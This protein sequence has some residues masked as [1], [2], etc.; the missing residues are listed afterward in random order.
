LMSF[1]G[2]NV[3]AYFDEFIRAMALHLASQ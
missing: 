3:P 1:F 2:P